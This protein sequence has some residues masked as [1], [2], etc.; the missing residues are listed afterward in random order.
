MTNEELIALAREHATYD[1]PYATIQLLYDIANALELEEAQKHYDQLVA[2]I[3]DDV[4]LETPLVG[5]VRLLQRP[6]N[7]P[8]QEEVIA[9]QEKAEREFNEAK[10]KL[11]GK[12]KS[13]V[14]HWI[15]EDK[16]FGGMYIECS[17]CG[18]RWHD[19]FDKKIP[20]S[21]DPCPVCGAIMDEDAT[22]YI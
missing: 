11:F 15:I 17:V 9:R 13:K 4:A 18:A 14:P 6:C 22:E 20:Y 21:D 16:G 3:P 7:P 8:T 10:E 12:K 19:L 5:E 1:L 2:V